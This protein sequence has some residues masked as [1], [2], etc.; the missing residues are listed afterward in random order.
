MSANRIL[1]I[2]YDGDSVQ[3][4]S[5]VSGEKFTCKKKFTILSS[6]PIPKYSRAYMEFTIKQH[7]SNAKIRHLPIY[8]G[9]HKE[10][11]VGILVADM[12]LGSIFYCN[13]YY[14]SDPKDWYHPTSFQSVER[15]NYNANVTIT[16]NTQKLG[17][18][19]PTV[20]HIIGIGVDTVAN[21]ISIYVEGHKMYSFKPTEF[22]INS[23]P[24]DFYFCI[25]CQENELVSGSVNFGRYK[26]E[27]TP[28]G[29][30]TLYQCWYY[31]KASIW[32]IYTTIQAGNIYP[33]PPVAKE[34]NM[35]ITAKNDIAPINFPTETHRNPY[36]IHSDP[37]NMAYGTNPLGMILRS[38]D[39]NDIS[40]LAWP[41]PTDQKI[42]LEFVVKNALMQIDSQGH[43]LY[44]GIPV[45]IGLTSAINTT[46]NQKVFWIDLAH[47][48][49]V[50][51]KKHSNMYNV[52]LEYN[53]GT[54][55][56]PCI[57]KQPDEWGMVFDLAHNK[58]DIYTLGDLFMSVDL[59]NNDFSGHQDLYWI[60]IQP[61]TDAFYIDN[62]ATEPAHIIVNTGE[63]GVLYDNIPDGKDIMTYY[64]YYNYLLKFKMFYDIDILIET[65]PYKT[66]YSRYLFCEITVPDTSDEATKWSPG[67]NKLWKTYNVV[68]DTEP[69]N[70][71]SD[72]TVFDLWNKVNNDAKTWNKRT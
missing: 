37:T 66:N 14:Y 16:K 11:S 20:N 4:N 55:L 61:I 51:Y 57:P 19:V 12:C 3:S 45:K 49:H 36:L 7:P 39:S 72:I 26:C 33:N 42:Y 34:F 59:V 6:K 18:R 48:R 50:A 30:W 41:I 64:Y 17:S 28:K 65:L 5:I 32:D 27:Y 43:M 68:T 29:Y 54:V 35:E 38:P 25:S 10:P 23:E 67:M 56:N 70:N 8:V 58:I 2:A 60:F 53:A 15:Y 69:H 47:K 63:N 52:P 22:N 13:P 1:P 46:S 44:D 62:A 9:I 71:E 24:D 40:T 31:K 21:T